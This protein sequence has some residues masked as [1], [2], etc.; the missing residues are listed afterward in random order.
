[1]GNKLKVNPGDLCK[2]NRNS[3][4]Y[5]IHE[6][7]QFIDNKCKV[8]KI[9][10]SGLVQVSLVSDSKKIFSFPLSNIDLLV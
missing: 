7:R 5:M 2:I 1:M 6:A 8:I 4:I 10:K 3:D 9:T